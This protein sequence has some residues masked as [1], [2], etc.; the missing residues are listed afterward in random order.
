[1]GLRVIGG[2]HD[3]DRLRRVPRVFSRNKQINKDIANCAH[4]L[5]MCASARQGR[6]PFPVRGRFLRALAVATRRTRSSG[7]VSL[8]GIDEVLVRDIH[9]WSNR[10]G[11]RDARPSVAAS[12][13]VLHLNEPRGRRLRP[14]KTRYGPGLIVCRLEMTW[15]F[16][17][18]VVS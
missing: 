13:G 11:A 10:L 18:P 7:M 17:G 8:V 14:T 5:C 1:M 2:L 4:D 16:G 6:A 9:R 12:L 3:C 15:N